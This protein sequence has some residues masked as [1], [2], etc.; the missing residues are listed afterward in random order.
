MFEKVYCPSCNASISSSSTKCPF[1][2][3][4]LTVKSVNNENTASSVKND[5]IIKYY[6][7]NSEID[8]TIKYYKSFGYTILKQEEYPNQTTYL[9]VLPNTNLANFDKIKYL[10]RKY[11]VVRSEF[12]KKKSKSTKNIAPLILAFFLAFALAMVG[13]I[14]NVLDIFA[15]HILESIPFVLAAFFLFIGFISIFLLKNINKKIDRNFDKAL[16]EIL[17]EAATLI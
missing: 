8:K 7:K 2:G 9:E 1:C 17:K 3:A 12:L 15:N 16:D 4:F 13:T 10:E 5:S 14:W 11:A 6:I